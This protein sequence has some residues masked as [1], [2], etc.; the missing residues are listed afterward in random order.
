MPLPDG[1]ARFNRRVTNPFMRTFAGRMPGMAIVEH[2][3]RS[4]GRQYRTPVNAFRTDDGC[5]IALTYGPDR[6]WVKNV[7]AAGGCTLRQRGRRVELGHPQIVAGTGLLPTPVRAVLR[8]LNAD[9]VLRL[10]RRD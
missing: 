5:A 2:L 6:D 3:G 1:L 10:R 4:S 8:V 9:S 7:Q